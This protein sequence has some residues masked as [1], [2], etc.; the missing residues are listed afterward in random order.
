MPMQKQLYPPNWEEIAL[1]LKEAAD[2]TCQRC[3][4]R[5]GGKQRN[6]H[7]KLVP[8][9]IGVAHLDHDPW[10][11]H[12]RLEVMCRTCHITYDA[13]DARRKRVMMAIA[14][15]QLVL[16]G[17]RS[18]YRPPRIRIQRKVA[19]H[20]QKRGAARKARQRSRKEVRKKA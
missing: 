3:G 5:R 13:K 9:Q 7:G 11:P 20:Q 14:R 15:G 6:R 12:A 8:V 2:W 19:R 4:A 16:P 17:L 1:Q 18:L 10:N